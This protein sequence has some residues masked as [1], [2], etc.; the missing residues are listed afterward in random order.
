MVTV[1]IWVLLL[2]VAH[3]VYFALASLSARPR[4]A[5]SGDLPAVQVLVAA[6]DEEAA[7]PRFLAALDRLDYDR[8]RISFVLVNDGSSDRTAELL[9]DWCGSRERA[10]AV[11]LAAP[12]GK[13]AALQAAWER[14]PGAELTALYDADVEPA[15][16]SLRLLVEEFRDERV[17]AATGPILPSNP[18][19]NMVTRYASLELW[20]YH[21]VTQAARDR[22]AMNPPAIGAQ[23]VY[24]TAAL[25]A[26]G[27]FPKY[28]TCSEDIETCFAVQRMGWRTSFCIDACVRTPVPETVAGFWAQRERWTRGPYQ[29]I[30]RVPGVTAVMITLGY[31]DRLVFL[32]LV[33]ASA[34]G[35]ASWAW[36][37]MY[38]LGPALHVSVALW[39]VKAPGKI[40]FLCSSLPMFAVDVGV[41]LIGT[42]KSLRIGNDSPGL[43]W[44]G[45][46]R[47]R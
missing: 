42:M 9:S 2:S 26:I 35:A 40:G 28:Q 46:R 11:R 23:S 18:A 1:L 24:R 33:A 8:A 3:R 6:R 41:T 12:C 39:R 4:A 14:A 7:L 34:A 36:P 13:S 16:D 44:K 19:V 22:L 45:T 32:A 29:A 31:T 17:G 38:F 30:R 47:A 21:L 10:V 37:A 15:P 27:G 5:A 20:T 43:G 25:Q